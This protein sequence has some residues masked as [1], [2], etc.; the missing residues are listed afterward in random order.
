ML[1]V[2]KI[3]ERDANELHVPAE[4]HAHRAAGEIFDGAMMT[5]AEH[6]GAFAH[7]RAPAVRQPARRRLT[8]TAFIAGVRFRL[9][10][11]Y[12][13]YGYVSIAV[14]EQMPRIDAATF[15]PSQM[16]EDGDPVR[17]GGIAE[18]AMMGPELNPRRVACARARTKR[19]ARLSTGQAAQGR[20]QE[21][22]C[23]ASPANIP[24][25]RALY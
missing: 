5:L 1:S 13:L 12:T 17:P 20:S 2:D 22:A 6:C 15:E 23:A 18:P 14:R 16:I 25:P 7:H 11:I 10:R 24:N 9:F 19:A 21:Q 3:E 4:R 8:G